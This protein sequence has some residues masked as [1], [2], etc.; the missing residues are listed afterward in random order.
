MNIIAAKIN[1]YEQYM[2]S[3]QLVLLVD[4]IPDKSNIIHD[5]YEDEGGIFYCG[6][7]DDGVVNF[8]LKSRNNS[9]GYYGSEFK[10]KTKHGEVSVIG[11]WSSRAGVANAL[12]PQHT[13]VEVIVNDDK[14]SFS[15]GYG[16]RRIAVKL[17]VAEKALK[18][19]NVDFSFTR[20]QKKSSG[21]NE[22]TYIIDKSLRYKI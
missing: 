18:M 6:S 1:W 10:L 13:C 12:F 9:D 11:P 14:S 16:G 15:K 4:K 2:N 3:A 7:S 21:L 17:E 20:E 5:I 8:C 19:I 22:I